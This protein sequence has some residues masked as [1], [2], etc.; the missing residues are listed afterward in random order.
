MKNYTENI[1]KAMVQ[2]LVEPG[3]KSAARLSTEVGISQATLSRWLR[4]YGNIYNMK[5]KL[6]KNWPPENKLRAVMDYEKLS[7]EEERGAFLR[8]NGLYSTT[9]KNWKNEILESLSN[10]NSSKKRKNN[11]DKQRIKELEK[12]LRRKDK[13]LAEAA[14]L[15]ILK[16]KADLLFGGKEDE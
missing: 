3:A 14:A 5:K 2:K 8:K 6:S 12:E 9:I 15:L 11:S 10:M 7:T 13:A 16:K 1:K 4:E